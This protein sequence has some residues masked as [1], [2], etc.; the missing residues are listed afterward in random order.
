MST[1]THIQSLKSKHA[2]LDQGLEEES[3][4]PLPDLVLMTE[5]KQKKLQ[6]KDEIRRLKSDL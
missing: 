6:I 5:L 3:Q 1:E 2:L 4:R